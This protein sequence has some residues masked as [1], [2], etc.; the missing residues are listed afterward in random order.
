MIRSSPPHFMRLE[1]TNS[2]D[3][4]VGGAEFNVAADLA[5]LNVT[6]AWVANG[7]RNMLIAP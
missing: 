4:N 2:F 7:R 6:S 5:R 3:M 1:Q